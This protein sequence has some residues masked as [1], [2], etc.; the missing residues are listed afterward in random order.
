MIIRV[1]KRKGITF[2]GNEGKRRFSTFHEN[3][4]VGAKNMP[5]FEDGKNPDH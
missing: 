5:L 2:L 4:L 3:L 1:W